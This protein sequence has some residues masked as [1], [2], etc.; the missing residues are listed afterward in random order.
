MAA[1]VVWK[2]A[3]W[4]INY[5]SLVSF[6]FANEQASECVLLVVFIRHIRRCVSMVGIRA[7]STSRQSVRSFHGEIVYIFVSL[8][9]INEYELLFF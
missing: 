2:C 8:S 1:E 6:F 3:E 7:L 4:K 9:S 5:N